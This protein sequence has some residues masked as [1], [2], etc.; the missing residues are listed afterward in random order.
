MSLKLPF[1]PIFVVDYNNE[2]LSTVKEQ[3]GKYVHYLT[4]ALAD[5]SSL[6]NSDIKESLVFVT[7]NNVIN[8]ILPQLLVGLYFL[9]RSF[10]KGTNLC[11]SELLEINKFSELMHSIISVFENWPQNLQP[12]ITV[13]TLK[14][15]TEELKVLQLSNKSYVW[16][17]KF[18]PLEKKHEYKLFDQ[19]F[20][21]NSYITTE[22]AILTELQ[23]TSKKKFLL[24]D[25]STSVQTLFQVILTNLEKEK[26]NI[27]VGDCETFEEKQFIFFLGKKLLSLNKKILFNNLD[28]FHLP[29][30]DLFNRL[31]IVF[32][33]TILD[34]K[35][36][37]EQYEII[38]SLRNNPAI[39]F[40]S[41]ESFQKFEE[42]KIFNENISIHNFPKK[43]SADNQDRE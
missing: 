2:T 32:V 9:E 12:I 43:N 6:S 36:F 22:D 18:I 8:P 27:V 29:F 42:L 15:E 13:F 34:Y 16:V 19:E 17:D 14:K 5:I 35:S 4:E 33:S 25:T 30:T 3:I 37:N 38:N 28:F 21:K 10:I 31:N 23:V 39:V 26:L 7:N 1:K 11:I 20:Y 24:E 41:D 40:L